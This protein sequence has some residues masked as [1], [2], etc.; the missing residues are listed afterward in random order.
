M[1][2]L[3]EAARRLIACGILTKMPHMLTLYRWSRAQRWPAVK[4]AAKGRGGGWRVPAA[5]LDTFEP[6]PLGRPRRK[7]MD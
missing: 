2:T 4:V 5:A 1:L 3:D 7:E 6:P